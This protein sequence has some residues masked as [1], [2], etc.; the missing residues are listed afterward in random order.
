MLDPRTV[1]T[2]L[3]LW[4]F[5][6]AFGCGDP[7]DIQVPIIPQEQPTATPTF[8]RAPARAFASIDVRA[9]DGVDAMACPLD[10]ASALVPSCEQPSSRDGSCG[11]SL[12]DGDDGLVKCSVIPRPEDPQMYDVD[13]LL[14]HRLLP[15]LAILGAM[16][17]A[18]MLPV[19][20]QVVTPQ[21]ASI[22]AECIAEAINLRSGAV[23][24]R[25]RACDAE[26]DGVA[27]PGCDVDVIAGFENCAR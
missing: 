15:R 25:L 12:R 10:Y 21:Q 4:L 9:A 1:S 8:M 14:E 23:Q 11:A 6:P 19:V 24:L 16:S 26:I 20:L 5:V 17:D 7:R 22:A 2:L 3:A 18:G 13:L 27:T